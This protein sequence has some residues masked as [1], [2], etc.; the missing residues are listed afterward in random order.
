MS[1]AADYAQRLMTWSDIQD[2]LEFLHQAV[3]GYRRPVVIELGVR[4]GMST[5][6]LLSAVS[7]AE[8]GR[9]W[10]ADIE[11][12]QVPEEWFGESAWRFVQGGSLDAA[13]LRQLPKHCHLLLLDTAHRYEHVLAELAAWV[14]RVRP[15]GMALVHGT[16]WAPGDADLGIPVGPVADALNEYCRETGLAWVNREGSYGMGV[17]R[18]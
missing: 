14:P 3:L 8:G 12:P 10:S 11:Q 5:S 17:I 16:Q 4:S 18:L 13:V 7:E 15:K 6:A 2:H 9:L 1:L